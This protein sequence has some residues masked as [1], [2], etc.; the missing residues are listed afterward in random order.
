[1]I[2]LVGGSPRSGKTVLGHRVSANLGSGWISTDLLYEILRVNNVEGTKTE[3][4]ASPAAI[5][6]AAEW[7]FPSL[8]RFVWRVSSSMIESYVIE[9]VDFLPNHVVQLA[10]KYSIR[11]VFLGCS[12]MTLE[13]FDQF[14]GHSLGY[15]ALPKEMRQQFAND[16]PKWSIFIQQEAKRFNLPYVDMSDD[17]PARLSEAEKL[18]TA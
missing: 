15:A 17:F 2:Y 1:M 16:V 9:G 6:E 18:L 3:W 13:R 11:S 7:F 10:D 14:P 4:D 12:K 8:E 5:I